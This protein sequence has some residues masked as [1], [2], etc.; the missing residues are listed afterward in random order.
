MVSAPVAL[1]LRGGGGGSAP[2]GAPLVL[3][4][5]ERAR[6]AP[7]VGRHRAPA[8]LQVRW[9]SGWGQRHRHVRG[10]SAARPQAPERW[11]PERR[12]GAD[13][14][15]AAAGRRAAAGRTA[16]RPLWAGG[17]AGLAGGSALGTCLGTAL[18]HP[19]ALFQ[20]PVAVL[21]FLVLPGELPQLVFELLDPHLGI[22]IV[23][24]RQRRGMPRER[25]QNDHRGQRRGT[26]NFM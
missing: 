1:V 25:T 22:D 20:L 24:L 11:A 26:G 19:Q 7:A 9:D 23:G 18:K 21:Q 3:P 10:P 6:R 4:R 2:A 5:A 12:S 8:A 13:S 15:Q 16:A 14:L 17:G